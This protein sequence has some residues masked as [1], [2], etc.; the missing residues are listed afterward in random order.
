MLLKL[1]GGGENLQEKAGHFYLAEAV[2]D[3]K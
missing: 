1:Q 2:L 3:G